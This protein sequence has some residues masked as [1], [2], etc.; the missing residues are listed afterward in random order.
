MKGTFFTIL[1]VIWAAVLAY[2]VVGW[3]RGHKLLYVTHERSA[4]IGLA[5][6]GLVVCSFGL[7]TQASSMNWLNPFN[8]A[9]VVLGAAATYVIAGVLLGWKVPFVSGYGSGFLLL[10]GII[11]LKWVL[12]TLHRYR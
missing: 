7:A 3:L 5:I 4:F 6:L 9:G 11:A 1:Q 2:F 10:T 12:T 8:V